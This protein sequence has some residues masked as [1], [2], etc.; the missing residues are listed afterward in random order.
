MINVKQYMN[1]NPKERA[2][3]K[4]IPIELRE[5]VLKQFQDIGFSIRLKYRGKRT[6]KSRFQ[7]QSYCLQKDANRFSIYIRK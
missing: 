5:E 3:Y 1:K 7:R 2:L 6:Q 4:N